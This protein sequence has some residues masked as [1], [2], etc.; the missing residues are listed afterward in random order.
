VIPLLSSEQMRTA[1]AA[2]TQLYG[3]E[4]LVARAGYALGATA[5][6]MLKGTYAKK[7]AV[8][9]GPGLNGADGRVAAQWLSQRGAKVT[10]FAAANAPAV[11]CG[12]DLVIDAAFGLGCS[13]DYFS[14][15]V[16][17]HTLV[18]ACDLPSGIDPDSGNLRGRPMV[19]DVTLAL[20]AFKPAHLMGPALEFVGETR[21]ADIGIGAKTISGILQH[22]DLAQFV[23]QHRDDH[24][25]RHAVLIV[26]GSAT[27]L[28]AAQLAV[29]GALSAGASMVRVCVP[30]LKAG[31]FGELPGEAVRLESSV[32]GLNDITVSV[33]TR[34]H[35]VVL[36]PG[37]GRTPAMRQAV[38]SMVDRC[39]VPLVLD[40]DGLHA[41]DV[42]CLATRTF[43][44]SPVILTPHEGEYTALVGSVPGDD[45]I[46]AARSLA[47]TTHCTVL[48]KGPV[49]IVADPEGNVRV[50]T[51]GTPAL[52]TAGTG[53]VLA[54]MIG[55]A[56]SRGHSPFAAASLAAQ[57]HAEAGQ[58]LVTYGG[59]HRLG[60][61]VAEVLG[62]FDHG[63]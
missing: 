43:R 37:L 47:A 38:R 6:E 48:L 13:R 39:R 31:R 3:T 4:A 32:E 51:A 1:D 19:A 45:R 40:A 57:L 62:E 55:A 12:F 61:A 23:R 42:R 59:A 41:V 22:D 21:F 27:M 17:D 63:S 14:P 36:G 33:S 9:A 8:V 54:G 16:D 20:G 30:G 25:W 35:S 52:A 24:K 7:V 10:V 34:L 2:A 50:V 46:G 58:R 5:R 18:L 26:A 15:N 44:D 29:T 56:L 11:L 60:D 28:G 49:T 53:D